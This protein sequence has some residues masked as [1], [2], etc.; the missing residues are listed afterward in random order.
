MPTVRDFLM[1]LDSEAPTTRRTLER[2]L[3]DKM[4]WAP[5]ERSLTLGQLAMHVANIPGVL[6]E[7][8]MKPSFD[9]STVI[10]RPTPASLDHLLTTHEESVAKARTLIGA[11]DDV[12]LATPWRMFNGNLEIASMPRGV[13]L[14]S[15]LFN[16]WYHHRGQLTVYLRET[17]AKVPSIYGASADEHPGA[18]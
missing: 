12:S 14:R 10:P 5:H 15:V 4:N 1:E 17:G 7:L 3:P 9:A 2:V 18:R 6:A 11:M 13:F 8:S 16:H